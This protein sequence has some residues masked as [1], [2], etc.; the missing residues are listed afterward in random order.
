MLH[1]QSNITYKGSKLR[2]LIISENLQ[3]AITGKFLYKNPDIKE[4]RRIFK[5][6]ME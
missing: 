6:T 5:D 1:R 3:Y 2:S 4:I